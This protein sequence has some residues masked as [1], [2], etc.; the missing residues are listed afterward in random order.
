MEFLT[1]FCT[2]T[3][4]VKE[5]NQD[6]LCIKIAQSSRGKILLAMICDGMGGLSK[7]EL[8]SKT[9][10]EAFAQWFDEQL[11]LLLE[12]FSLKQVE[13]QWKALIV[14][15]NQRI[16]RFGRQKNLTL[17]T[18]WTALLLAEGV[19]YLIGH[20]GDCRI[21]RLDKDIYQLT[22]DQTVAAR[23][24]RRGD[25][26]LEEARFDPRRNVLLQ[27]I[28]ASEQVQPVFQTGQLQSQELYLL[29]SDGFRHEISREEIAQAF[30][31]LQLAGE[32][33]MNQKAIELV[34]LNKQRQERDN[35]TVIAVKVI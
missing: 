6:S 7:G 17:G 22:E 9:V 20:V 13:E 28:G 25:L 3:G 32:Q 29:C 35:I 8:A 15:Q 5:T 18:T 11:P 24:I 16:G 21:Y 14:Q 26:T 4:I 12:N 27:C 1:A 2:D 23:D 30:L 10:T 33:E 34:E 19:G 31:P